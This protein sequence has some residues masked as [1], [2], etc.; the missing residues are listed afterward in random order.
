MRAQSGQTFVTSS[1]QSIKLVRKIADGGEGTVFEVMGRP[2]VVAKTYH[3]DL[4][5]NVAEKLKAMV[6]SASS[7]PSLLNFAAWPKELLLNPQRRNV[8]GFLMPNVADHRNIHQLYS[9]KDRQ[10]YFPTADWGFLVHTALNCCVSFEAIHKLGHVLGDVNHSNVLVNSQAMVRVIDCDSMG[11]KDG[12]HWFPC[13]DVGVPEFTAPEL[14]TR[15]FAGIQRNQNHDLFGLA[16]L[17]FHLLF[18]GRHPFMGLLRQPQT[19]DLPEI[20]T[21][22]KNSDFAYSRCRQARLVPPRSVPQL[23]SVSPEVANLFEKAFTD[24]SASHPPARPTATQWRAALVSLEKSLTTCNRSKGHKFFSAMKE[25]PW[26]I[27]ATN[28]NFDFFLTADTDLANWTPDRTEIPKI[29]PE[30]R[31]HLN[32]SD[33]LVDDLAHFSAIAPKPLPCSLSKRPLLLGSPPEEARL[34][35]GLPPKPLVTIEPLSPPVLTPKPSKP[36]PPVSPPMRSPLRPEEIQLIDVLWREAASGFFVIGLLLCLPFLII[37]HWRFPGISAV[38]F[39]VV[40]VVSWLAL[41]VFDCIRKYHEQNNEAISQWKQK[42]RGY[43]VEYRQERSVES[44]QFAEVHS[45]WEKRCSE[46][47]TSNQELMATHKLRVIKLHADHDRSQ[48]TADL[49]W[50]SDNRLLLKKWRDD[51][52]VEK[53]NWFQKKEEYERLS[54]QFEQKRRT[55]LEEREHRRRIVT[56]IEKEVSSLQTLQL[57]DTNTLQRLKKELQNIES[58]ADGKWTTL[59][60]EYR[61]EVHVSE[62]VEQQIKDYLRKKPIPRDLRN[63]GPSRYNALITAGIT[64]A[65]DCNY[66][67]LVSVH[68]IGSAFASTIMVWS[69]SQRRQFQPKKHPTPTAHRMRINSKFGAL[70]KKIEGELRTCLST[71][72][73]GLTTCRRNVFER[74]ERIVNLQ[75]ELIQA[76]VDLSPLENL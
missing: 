62:N 70:A 4:N 63:I 47:E 19:G 45:N 2:E 27:I 51:L 39:T 14:Q 75:K 53:L 3:H 42:F 8:I 61:E 28:T 50:E 76:R 24:R 57:N 41:N 33:Q 38:I 12:L 1:N 55:L 10:A 36:V 52:Q 43:E 67:S 31:M 23:D 44:L 74:H 40:V 46:I 21:S 25:C 30:I 72:G 35:V 11:I 13:N 18:V 59:Q 15:S 29:L 5:D 6:R 58:N 65:A 16:V 7:N 69:D 17:I 66:S 54:I 49:Q 37:I 48:E 60:Q 20:G 68:G 9:P 22:I 56:Q 26:C 32:V 34:L 64:S 71:Y 73:G